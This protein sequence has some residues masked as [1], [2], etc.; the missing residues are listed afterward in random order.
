MKSNVLKLNRTGLKL[1]FCLLIT[2]LVIFVIVV[3]SANARVTDWEISPEIPKSGDTLLIS[4]LASPEEELEVSISFEKTVSVY[5]KE[6]SYEFENIDILNFNNLFAVKAEGAENLKVKMK[7]I[8]SKTESVWADEGIATVS[9]SGVSPG[10]YNVR[11]EGMAE[12]G[13]SEVNLKITTVQ[14]VKAGKDG[15]FSYIYKTESVPAEKLEIRVGD[16]KREIIFNAKGKTPILQDVP[17]SSQAQVSREPEDRKA[18]ELMAPVSTESIDTGSMDREN[19][20]K[21]TVYMTESSWDEN[22][23]AAATA[24]E[25]PSKELAKKQGNQD[26]QRTNFPYLLAGVVTGFGGVLVTRRKK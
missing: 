13:A 1:L 20:E 3:S 9:Y 24:G 21:H 2:F 26:Q 23:T 16:S 4:G 17:A 7:M 6:Y 25:V 10:E 22:N 5:L 19:E 14:K 12:D 15:K 11:V 18:S 8:L